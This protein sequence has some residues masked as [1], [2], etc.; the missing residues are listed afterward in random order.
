[1]FDFEPKDFFAEA[2]AAYYDLMRQMGPY[3]NMEILCALYVGIFDKLEMGQ[4]SLFNHEQSLSVNKEYNEAQ[5]QAQMAK[6]LTLHDFLMKATFSMISYCVDAMGNHKDLKKNVSEYLSDDLSYKIGKLK[7][8]SYPKLDLFSTGVESLLRNS[9]AHQT[10]QFVNHYTILFEDRDRKMEL[11]LGSFKVYV[12]KLETNFDAQATALNLF[13]YDNQIAVSDYMRK[14]PVIL[15][16]RRLQEAITESMK[17][18]D[19]I[20]SDLSVSETKIFCKIKKSPGF[21]GPQET[22]G[23]VGNGNIYR[24]ARPALDLDRQVLHLIADISDLMPKQAE[25]EVLVLN[26]KGEPCRRYEFDLQG[27]I[28][29]INEQEPQENGPRYIKMTSLLPDCS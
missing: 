8:V 13:V 3:Q 20:P 1:M 15:T 11:K 6:Y 12:E 9:I 17:R 24:K 7:K 22:I 28:R 16:E 25:L 18:L 10:Y 27:T 14:N 2:V 26:F 19:F 23:R 4:Q 29:V 5:F 21:D